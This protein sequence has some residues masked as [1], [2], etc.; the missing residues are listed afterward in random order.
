M[1][2]L[3][4]HSSGLLAGGG[5]DLP[6]LCM[7]HTHIAYVWCRQLWR[8]TICRRRYLRTIA[9]YKIMDAYRKYKLKSYLRKI[10]DLFRGVERS[11]D[12]GKR[13]RWPEPPEV[14]RGYVET[15][16]RVHRRCARSFFFFLFIVAVICTCK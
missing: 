8:G 13:V 6:V 14:L 12:F 2:S 11:A 7:L 4:L 1:L 3:W 16:K 15:L 10:N 9:I 5:T